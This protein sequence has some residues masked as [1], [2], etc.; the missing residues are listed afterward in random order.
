MLFG[1]FIHGSLK[2]VRSKLWKLLYVP[3][4]NLEW[5]CVRSEHEGLP[6][7]LRFP[8]L[9]LEESLRWR[10]RRLVVITLTFESKSVRANGLPHDGYNDGLME[11]DVEITTLFEEGHSGTIVLVETFGGRRIFYFYVSASCDVGVRFE[12]LRRK[13]PT[14]DL[15]WSERSDPNWTFW[16]RYR[17][18]FDLYC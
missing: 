7:F 9:V 14:L 4:R 17:K 11:A 3:S 18:E 15:S 16:D 2:K 12:V 13:H 8:V 6:L 10:Y 5:K 1:G